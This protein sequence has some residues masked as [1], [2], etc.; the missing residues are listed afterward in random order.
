MNSELLPKIAYEK[1]AEIYKIMANQTRLAILNF[2]RDSEHSVEEIT[3]YVGA[4]KANISQHLALLRHAGL[5]T[6][7]REGT[8]VYYKIVDSRIVAP[9]RILYDIWS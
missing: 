1:N 6:A 8:S 7:R 2:C 3:K 9:C 4:R 5:V